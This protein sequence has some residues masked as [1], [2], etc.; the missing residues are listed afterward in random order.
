MATRIGIRA[1]RLVSLLLGL[2]FLTFALVSLS[3]IDPVTA[4]LNPAMGATD[5]Q[6][7]ALEQRWGLN[8]PWPMRYLAWLTALISGDFGI[9]QIYQAPVLGIITTAFINS[10]LLMMVSWILSG[11]IGYALGCLAAHHRGTHLDRVI[12][13]LAYTLASTPT[14]VVGLVLLII[15]GVLLGIAPIGLSQPVGMFSED[16]T[17]ANRLSHFIL[18]CVAVTL[19][20]IAQAT[21]HSRQAMVDFLESEVATFATARGKSPWR[22]FRDHGFRN[23]V[24]PI[25]VLQCSFFSELFGGSALAEVVFSYHGLGSVMTEAGL[26]GDLPL[27]LGAVMVSCLFVFFGNLLADIITARVD[28]R[29][30]AGSRGNAKEES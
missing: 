17:L 16:V 15:F 20:G 11:I 23:T 18:P 29:T 13:W 5:A 8:E 27:L 14:F 19:L 7:A 1:L 28:T 12:S 21:L 3:P 25:I 22:T 30:L 4:Y 10:L 6:L 9:S 2:S 24:I 26:R